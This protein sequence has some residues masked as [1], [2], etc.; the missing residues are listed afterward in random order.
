MLCPGEQWDYQQLFKAYR[1]QFIAAVLKQKANPDWTSPTPAH[2]LH[3]MSQHIVGIL[4]AW[5]SLQ[6][7][8]CHA[9]FVWYL[10]IQ[11]VAFAGWLGHAVHSN[12]QPLLLCWPQRLPAACRV[13]CE[14]CRVWA[15]ALACCVAALH[16]DCFRVL[17]DFMADLCG[18]GCHHS[19]EIR[20]R[21]VHSLMPL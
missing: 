21:S 7:C 9:T 14:P 20:F 8:F 19:T 15:A 13:L 16:L 17:P 18:F 12:C 11:P 5:Q 2:L 10:V 4:A 3:I 6:T 1:V